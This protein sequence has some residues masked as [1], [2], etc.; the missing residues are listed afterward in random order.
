MKQLGKPFRN[1][2]KLWLYGCMAVRALHG[3][4]G[5]YC[6]MGVCS[7]ALYSGMCTEAKF[8]ERVREIRR[9]DKHFGYHRT[10]VLTGQH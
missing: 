2:A 10:A 8:S 4:E 5:E 9:D 3:D 6:T 1:F 7:S